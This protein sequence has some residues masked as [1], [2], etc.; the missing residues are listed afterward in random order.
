MSATSAAPEAPKQTAEVISP[1]GRESTVLKRDALGLPALFFCIATAAAPLTALLFNVPVIASGAGTAIPAAFLVATA[2]LL[3]FSV[4]YVEMARR[5]TSAGGFYSFVSHGFGQA[6]GLATAAVVTLSYAVLVGALVG[7]FG[8]FA[9]TSIADW[10]GVSISIAVLLFGVLLVDVLFLWFDIRI[11]ARVLAVFFISEI[12][13]ALLLSLVIVGQGGESGLTLSPFDPTQIFDNS[14]AI[15]VFGAAAPGIALFGAFWSFVG[16]EMAPN[17]GEET[18]SARTVFGRA[19]FATVLIL[20]ALYAFAAYAF[21]VGYGTDAVAQGMLAQF[22]GEV[23]SAWY[24]LT[25]RYVGSWLTTAFE[26]LIITSTF[27]SQLAFFNT[28]ARYLYA[29]GREGILPRA[30]GRTEPKHKTPHI[31]GAVLTAVVALFVLAF[32]LDDPSTEAAL[33]K[34]GTWAPLLGVLGILLVQALVS[35]AIVRYFRKVEPEHGHV[36]KTLI[37]P[38]LGGAVMLFSA[39]LLLDNRETLAAAEGVP[40]VQVIQWVIVAVFAFGFAAALWFRARDPAR[41]EAVGR[42]VH[43]DA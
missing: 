41:Y 9:A 35:F 30:L 25:D 38:L 22:N 5:V 28:A 11:T 32:Y 3:V 31:A 37:A 23:A 20:G 36:W 27:T 18:R 29:L 14:A 8:Y 17:Y 1:A 12:A 21:V 19:T 6:A 7:V 42:F 39:Y 2:M 33:L 40:F 24:P 10:T 15:A 4:G 26:A 34:L 13:A 43:E 16:F